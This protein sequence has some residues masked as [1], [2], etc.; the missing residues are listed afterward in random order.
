M[1]KRCEGIVMGRYDRGM[2]CVY[3]LTANPQ[4]FNW[5]T[6][7]SCMHTSM[8]A[9]TNNT[10][11]ANY[12]IHRAPSLTGKSGTHPCSPVWKWPPLLWQNTDFSAQN[13]PFFSIKYRLFSPKWTPLFCGKTLTFEPKWTPFFTVKHWTSKLTSFFIQIQGGEYQNTTFF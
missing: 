1:E 5:R 2:R 7:D 8:Q 6:T 4:H 10:E 3:L 13:D 11:R 12:S 9:A